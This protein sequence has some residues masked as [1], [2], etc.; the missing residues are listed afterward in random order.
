MPKSY[1]ITF[2]ENFDS[3]AFGTKPLVFD[4]QMQ[5][6]GTHPGPRTQIHRAPTEVSFRDFH[7]YNI[8]HEYEVQMWGRLYDDDRSFSKFIARSQI[9][10][11]QSPTDRIMLMCGK[12]ADILDFCRKTQEF[13][14]VKLRTIQI[15]MKQLQEKLP[16]VRGAWF[17]F[18]AMAAQSTRSFRSMCV[19]RARII[20]TPWASQC[21]SGALSSSK[22]RSGTW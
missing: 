4:R 19:W 1:K 7:A 15:D 13:P 8:E 3:D 21:W 16:E 12:K 2:T 9:L 17:R 20:S 18:R 10:A 14:H 22:T 5:I 6:Q 11:Y